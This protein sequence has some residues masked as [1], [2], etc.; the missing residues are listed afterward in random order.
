MIKII[1]YRNKCIGCGICVEQQP[2]LWRMSRKDGKATL[3]H[4]EEKKG[5]FQRTSRADAGISE[6]VAAACPTKVI[7]ITA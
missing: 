4:A 7:K 5:I 6:R 2:D 3:L 1:H